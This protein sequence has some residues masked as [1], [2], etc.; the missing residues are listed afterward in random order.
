MQILL[1][2]PEKQMRNRPNT[3]VQIMQNAPTRCQKHKG[4]LRLP[5]PTITSNE[6]EITTIYYLTTL[7]Q[8]R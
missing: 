1:Q 5:L 3:R 7:F 8:Q 4:L 2:G 6:D